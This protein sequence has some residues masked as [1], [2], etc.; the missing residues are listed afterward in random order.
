[1]LEQILSLK[2]LHQI[3]LTVLQL[4]TK[5]QQPHR[6]LLLHLQRCLLQGHRIGRV[7]YLPH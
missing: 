1:V 4:L 6:L 3:L 2:L 7:W 5:N